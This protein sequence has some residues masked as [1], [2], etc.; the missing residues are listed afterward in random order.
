MLG[1]KILNPLLNF[2]LVYPIF[3]SQ[4]VLAEKEWT[5]AAFKRHTEDVFHK[6][7]PNEPKLKISG[8][9]NEFHFDMPLI[10]KVDETLVDAGLVFI[11]EEE[12]NLMASLRLETH[13]PHKNGPHTTTSFLSTHK[14][15]RSYW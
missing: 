15:L 1:I 13:I 6:L 5:L 2:C 11:L 8:L 12:V 10:Y 3:F 9:Q 4:Q 7:Y 14:V